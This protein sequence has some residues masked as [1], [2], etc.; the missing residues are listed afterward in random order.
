MRSIYQK[1][2]TNLSK[3]IQ[4]MYLSAQTTALS[5]LPALFSFFGLRSK[6]LLKPLFSI[7]EASLF[8]NLVLLVGGKN[9]QYHLY[10]SRTA[11]RD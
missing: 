11:Y 10:S 4:N 1:T 7:S 6:W 5:I 3:K 9:L 8:Q 2:R